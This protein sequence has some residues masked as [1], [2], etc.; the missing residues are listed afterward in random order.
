MD[1]VAVMLLLHNT[2]TLI[3]AYK[4]F[5][6]KDSTL[7]IDFVNNRARVAGVYGAAFDRFT[8]TRSTTGTYFDASGSIQTAAINAPRFDVDTELNKAR[9][10]VSEPTRSNIL[11]NSL[12]DGTNLATQSVTVAAGAYTLSF[13]GTGSITL[14][15]A[16]TGT[17][18]G[19]SA[20]RRVYLI[21]TPTAGN[22]TVTVSGN[23][24]WAQLEAGTGLTSFIPTDGTSKSRG[25]D[26]AEISGAN[27]TDW[28]SNDIGS[29]IVQYETPSTVRNAVPVSVSDGTAN[30]VAYMFAGISTGIGEYYS[31]SAGGV[32][33]GNFPSIGSQSDA[34]IATASFAYTSI[35]A[36]G[37]NKIGARG[38]TTIT[39]P[40]CNKF[41]LNNAVNA[42]QLGGWIRRVIYIPRYLSVSELRGVIR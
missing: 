9:G 5:P 27:L 25:A 3:S 21:F 10:F 35:L 2:P 38:S 30:N 23:V 1:R 4:R 12:I 31:V 16:A 15:G 34:Q 13:Y 41:A 33:Q 37:V 7:D 22:L 40:T 17:L 11:L 36:S 14:S 26:I 8:F 20:T 42:G 6:A 24:K 29:L 18:A 32:S 28:F 39:F 19:V